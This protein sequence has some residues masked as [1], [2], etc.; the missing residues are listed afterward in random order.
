M[1]VSEDDSTWSA[2]SARD[3]HFKTLYSENT[4]NFTVSTDTQTIS[5]TAPTPDGWADGTV[6]DTAD[7][8][9]TPLTLAPGVNNIYYS[10]N[11]AL[12][13]DGETDESLQCIISDQSS[14][15]KEGY[16][17]VS[18]SIDT[19]SGGIHK[20]AT[21]GKYIINV[22]IQGS[23]AKVSVVGNGT[24]TNSLCKITAVLSRL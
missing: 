10:S 22:P 1:K 16:S 19:I 12:T 24:V 3:M 17:A 5:V 15:F 7:L 13:A 18:T 11:G 4:T 8:G 6:I 23:Y 21:T 20:I 2:A 9:V 14:Y